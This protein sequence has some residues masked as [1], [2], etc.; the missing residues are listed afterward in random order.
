M[1]R[2]GGPH[3][4]SPRADARAPGPG[5]AAGAGRRLGGVLRPAGRR[6]ARGLRAAPPQRA[7]GR[8]RGRR[9]CA[10]SSTRCVVDLCCGTGALGL[11]VADRVQPLD[12][13]A[14]DLDPAAV[15]SHGATSARSGST[16]ATC[17]TPCRARCRPGR[18]AA[19]ERAVR[20]DRGDRADAAGGARPRAPGRARR[21][22]RR[23]R[24]APAGGGR[25]PRVAA[26]RR[27]AAPETSRRAGGGH[28]RR[29]RAGRPAQRGGPREETQS[30]AVRAWVSRH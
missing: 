14:A 2:G 20:P 24:P 1:L 19:R 30:T 26:A 15:A 6:G 5:R 12:L 25:G 28:P 8:P 11:A 21:W 9:T 18:R 3:P 17:T 27:G 16:R 7:A 29:L 22:G 10:G 13:H 23:A 4:G